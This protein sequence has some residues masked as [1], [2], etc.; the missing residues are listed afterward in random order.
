MKNLK[1]LFV[2]TLFISAFSCRETDDVFFPA[3]DEIVFQSEYINYAWGKQHYGFIITSDGTKYSYDNPDNWI[4]PEDSQIKAEDFAA[5]LV[6]CTNEGKV[7]LTKF[8]RMKTLVLKVDETKLSKGQNV[9]ADAGS[10]NY[11]FHVKDANKGTYRHITL[12]TR[13]DWFQEN[14]DDDAKEIANWLIQLNNGGIFKD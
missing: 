6:S 11:S 12:V 7:D 2:F 5:N 8:N 13:G 9:M 10:E 14:T 4:F 3:T 1:L